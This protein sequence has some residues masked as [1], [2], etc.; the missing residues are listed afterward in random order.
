MD[1]AIGAAIEAG[2][3]ILT[4]T[5]RLARRIRLEHA[6]AQGE[7]GARAWTAPP[8]YAWQAWLRSQY[9]SL[10]WTS[11]GDARALLNSTQ[12]QRAWERIVAADLSGAAL[13]ASATA[14]LAGA[15]WRLVHGW[16]LP[17]PDREPLATDEVRAFARWMH[18]FDARCAEEGWLDAARLP[19]VLRQAFADG[20]VAASAGVLLVGFDR[21]S[22]QQRELVRA[23]EARG[24]VVD[25]WQAP[26]REV[27][28]RRLEFASAEHELVSVARWARALLGDE[29]PS[30][31]GVVV[32]RLAARAE[33]VRRIFDEILAPVAALPGA[34]RASP[35]HALAMDVALGEQ[36]IVRAARAVLAFLPA[37]V[38]FADLSRLLRS[39]FIAGGITCAPRR[40]LFDEWLR[41]RGIVEVD[42]SAL[43]GLLDAFALT[44]ATLAVDEALRDAFAR[45]SSVLSDL[46]STAS[47]A[48]WV[49]AIGRCLQAF[50]WPGERSP[51]VAE[52][53]AVVAFE[54]ALARF[55][56]LELIE[57]SFDARDAVNHF[58]GVLERRALQ[59]EDD[60]APIQVLDL[61]DADAFAFDALWVT[62]LDD[63][64]W[65]PP[66]DANPFLPVEWQR[67]FELPGGTP[68]AQLEH[69]RRST[70]RLL[71]A[72]DLV[73]VSHARRERADDGRGP[74]P[75]VRDCALHEAS[76]PV[77]QEGQT[78]GERWPATVALE[79]LYDERAPALRADE[80]A[81]GG[82]RMLELQATCPF[83]AFADLRLRARA[84][85]SPSAALDARM[86]GML[87]HGA[88]E[89]LWRELGGSAA[90]NALDEES[91]ARLLGDVARDALDALEAEHGRTLTPRRRVVEIGRLVRT[92]SGWIALE[93]ARAPFSIHAL[94][95]RRALRIGGID[96]GTRVDRVDRLADDSLV[97][98]DYK[99][100]AG[101]PRAPASWAGARPDEPQLPLY[102][103]AETGPLAGLLIGHVRSQRPRFSG[104]ARDPSVA[105][106]ASDGPADGF[107][108]ARAEW[109]DA[110]GRLASAY[111]AGD[112]RVDPK[113][114]TQTCRRCELGLFCRIGERATRGTNDD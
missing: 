17:D 74:S 88:L 101:E 51:T 82:A 80:T 66:V 43:P 21:L 106:G 103:L 64:T 96:L 24:I 27:R 62:G 39:P 3:T 12:E 32:P 59:L 52:E 110:L 69:A 89:R 33:L 92:L 93:R 15:A 36:P 104:A 19:D 5:T 9:E 53:A 16:R 81:R 67:R 65:P 54:E 14:R 77:L 40:A 102:A 2:H 57:E 47:P 86:R 76:S 18:A 78:A 26:E 91:G 84:L 61:A 45:A 99:T 13:D 46:A 28:A 60:T 98:I 7:R 70:R 73:L 49:T 8:V 100:G 95:A 112:A 75:L 23:L 4:S 48:A 25:T 6:R 37:R 42:V 72:C 41:E 109:R 29:R 1:P 55:A 10:R 107:T 105:P 68:E 34:I 22:P 58:A 113:H 111:A 90:L 97:I 11:A 71:H 31:I 35:T 79:I 85:P 30:R 63:E 56:S 87:V 44:H 94:E 20:A 38:A 83:R 108:Q 114:G 50:G